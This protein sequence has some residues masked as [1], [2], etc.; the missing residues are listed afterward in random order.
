MTFKNRKEMEKAL[1]VAM[2]NRPAHVSVDRKVEQ[3]RGALQQDA[4]VFAKAI[5]S[6]LK[7]D[8]PN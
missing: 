7:T 5:Q 1:K 6:M 8:R 4:G 3:L 2:D